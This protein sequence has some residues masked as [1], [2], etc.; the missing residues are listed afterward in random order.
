MYS[1]S[2][3]TNPFLYLTQACQLEVSVMCKSIPP[4][5]GNLY[6]CLFD[7]MNEPTMKSEVCSLC[8]CVSQKSSTFLNGHY[9]IVGF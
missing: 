8:V 3:L 2:I 7:H 9:G 4:G 5:K 1:S 6:H